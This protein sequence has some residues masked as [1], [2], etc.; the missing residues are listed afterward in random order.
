MRSLANRSM[1]CQVASSNWTRFPG[2]TWLALAD[3]LCRL[4]EARSIPA[5]CGHR[6]N[7]LILFRVPSV[8]RGRRALEG[9]SPHRQSVLG[10]D[11]A[12]AG[13]DDPAVTPANN[14]LDAADS[15]NGISL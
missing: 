6:N 5:P 14:R 2:I 15:G 12:F 10:R 9:Q 3:R 11:Q 8:A 7:H 13:R 1:A 4:G